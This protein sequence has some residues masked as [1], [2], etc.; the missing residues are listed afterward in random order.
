MEDTAEGEFSVESGFANK[1][2]A[3]ACFL[4]VPEVCD[5]VWMIGGGTACTCVP[6]DPAELIPAA[7]FNASGGFSRQ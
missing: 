2:T 1:A 7:A 6:A 4:E 3:G 5:E